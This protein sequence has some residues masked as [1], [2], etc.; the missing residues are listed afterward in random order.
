[1]NIECLWTSNYGFIFIGQIPRS[2]FAGLYNLCMFNFLKLK[3]KKQ[4][5]IRTIRKK[6]TQKKILYYFLNLLY[7]F[8]FQPAMYEGSLPIPGIV[9]LL[10]LITHIALKQWSP[11]PWLGICT[12]PCPIRTGPHS[13]RWEQVKL[14][15]LVLL[16]EPLHFHPVCRKTGCYE[17]NLWCHKNW[18]PLI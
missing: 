14:H 13:M 4:T 11:V 6:P 15:L 9:K 18:D 8:A 7:H 3:T 10:N 12:G 1:M 2:E 17:T 5:Q 16:L